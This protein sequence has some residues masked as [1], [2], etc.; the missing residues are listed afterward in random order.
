MYPWLHL[1]PITI[2]TYSLLFLGFIPL[3]LFFIGFVPNRGWLIS[4]AL[5]LW[6]VTLIASIVCILIARIRYIGLWAFDVRAH[7]PCRGFNRVHYHYL[8]TK[9]LTSFNFRNQE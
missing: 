5:I 6:L 3:V 7:H 8:S 1:G 4:L 2:S 9:R